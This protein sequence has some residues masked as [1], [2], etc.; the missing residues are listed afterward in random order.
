MSERAIECFVCHKDLGLIR[1]AKLRVNISHVCGP[2]TGFLQVLMTNQQS[3]Q[4][5]NDFADIFGDI[6]KGGKF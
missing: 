5:K 1:D 3:G 2:C 6:F 4:K